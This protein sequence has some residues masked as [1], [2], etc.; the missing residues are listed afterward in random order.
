ML[1]LVA[2]NI[3]GGGYGKAEKLLVRA[4]KGIAGLEDMV[5]SETVVYDGPEA[6]YRDGDLKITLPEAL[7]GK[8]QAHHYAGFLEFDYLDEGREWLFVRSETDR[9]PAGQ[10]NVVGKVRTDGSDQWKHARIGL[11]PEN[12]VYR[13]GVPSFRFG[14]DVRVRDISLEFTIFTLAAGD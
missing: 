12:I 8:L 14:G 10:F 5:L 7:A 6:G 1:D 3:A 2:A 4:E 9:E 11:F 13:D